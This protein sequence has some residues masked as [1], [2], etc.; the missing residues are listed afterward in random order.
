MSKNKLYCLN[1]DKDV[2][3]DIVE[4][5]ET[6]I[7]KGTKINVLTKHAICKECG[8]TIFNYQLEK[9]NQ[10]I[11][12]DTYKAQVN[13]LTSKE[14]ISIRQKYNLSQVELARIIKCGEKNIARYE[15]G[16]IQDA[17]IDLL[18]R[19]VDKIPAYFGLVEKTEINKSINAEYFVDNY[20]VVYD[21]EKKTRNEIGGKNL[22][23][24]LI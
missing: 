2:L 21:Q 16:A 1:C 19:L 18:I 6:H 5:Q 23:P 24:Q 10:I 3:F 9:Q 13:L 8:S 20:D 22:C 17:S 7:I 14:I 15:N 12:S 4:V 11:I